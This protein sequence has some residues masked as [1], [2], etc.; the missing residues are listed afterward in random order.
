[1]LSAQNI[2]TT[3]VRTRVPFPPCPPVQHRVSILRQKIIYALYRNRRLLRRNYGC[4]DVTKT[5]EIMERNYVTE[6]CYEI[7]LR[8]YVKKLLR[9]TKNKCNYDT[10]WRIR[11]QEV[12]VGVYIVE[13]TL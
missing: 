9:E 3:V 1:M 7:T 4:Y 6:L 11:N 8:N 12:K 13:N 2:R 5:S 10:L